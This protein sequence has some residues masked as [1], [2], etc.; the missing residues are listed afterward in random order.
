V[1]LCIGVLAFTL[2]VRATDNMS[3]GTR[4]LLPNYDETGRKL[5]PGVPRSVDT[6]GNVVYVNH[7]FTTSAYQKEAL[8]LVI[9][10]AN[11]IAWQ[12]KL[13]EEMPIT[14]SNLVE[15]HI[16]PFGF[17]YAYRMIGNITTKKFIYS[18]ASDDKLNNCCVA[19]YD[20][21]CIALQQQGTLPIG[22]LD[23]N[24][25]YQ[26]TTQWLQSAH[27]DVRKLN[28]DCKVKIN[29]SEFWNGLPTGAQFSKTNFV[30]IYDISWLSPQNEIKHYGDVA[31]VELYSP[32]KKLLQLSIED[33]KYILRPPLQFTNLASL[34]P[35][36]APVHTNYPVKAVLITQPLWK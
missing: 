31:F 5:P 32:T 16:S 15:Y 12:L 4:T 35:G 28:N 19:N 34:F 29:I 23:T 8:K 9:Q 13:P 14:E 11:Q 7:H 3:D 30:P 1:L 22:D 27:V 36:V 21:Q 6:N 25:A 26:L 33:S 17:A 18:V 10:E 24:L 2:D 20:Q